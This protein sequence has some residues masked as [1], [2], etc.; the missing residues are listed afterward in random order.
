M[1]VEGFTL[2]TGKVVSNVITY[3]DQTPKIVFT[4]LWQGVRWYVEGTDES[5]IQQAEHLRPEHE[6]TIMGHLF[7]RGGKIA[8]RA[9]KI[10]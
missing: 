6:I 2:L 3:N 10:I 8:V 4:L 5:L 9:S 1:Q 7:V